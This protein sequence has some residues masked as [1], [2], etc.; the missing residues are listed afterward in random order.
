MIDYDGI[1]HQFRLMGKHLEFKLL[2]CLLFHLSA[3]SFR[4]LEFWVLDLAVDMHP[5]CGDY[6]FLIGL[7]V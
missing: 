2:G 5:Y 6:V 1:N 3:R 7:L 4:V